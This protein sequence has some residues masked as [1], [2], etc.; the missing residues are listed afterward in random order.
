MK[1]MKLKKYIKLAALLG[2]VSIAMFTSGCNSCTDTDG[3]KWGKWVDKIND[4]GE[5]SKN[6]FGMHFQERYCE[7]CGKHDGGMN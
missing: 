7:T 2:V 6:G 1:T 4:E 5:P 3:H